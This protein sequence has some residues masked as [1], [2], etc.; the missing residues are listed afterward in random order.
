MI[1]VLIKQNYELCFDTRYI[2]NFIDRKFLFEVFPSI[3]VKKISTFIIVRDIDVNIYNINEYVK[4]QI[5]LFDKN[6]VIKVKR[7]LYIIDNFAIKILIDNDI[8]KLKNM[9]LDIKKNVIIIDLYKNIQIYFIF[10]NHRSRIRV[11][12]FNNN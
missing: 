7:E 10:I 3:V 6:N 1:F 11:T 8:I 9:I 5:Y 2:I 12:I 4:L